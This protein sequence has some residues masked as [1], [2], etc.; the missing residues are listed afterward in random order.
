M[1]KLFVAVGILLA[2]L[3]AKAEVVSRDTVEYKGE[4]K[5]EKLEKSNEYGEVSVRYIAF[6]YAITNKKGEPRKVTINKATYEVGKIT[7]LVYNNQ[8]SGARRISKAIYV[9]GK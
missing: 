7:H 5:L 4:Y 2:T 6:L 1:K 8:D 3:T 9:S